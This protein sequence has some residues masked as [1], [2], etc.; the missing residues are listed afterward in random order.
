MSGKTFKFGKWITNCTD[1]I[2]KNIRLSSV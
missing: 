1:N 2:S